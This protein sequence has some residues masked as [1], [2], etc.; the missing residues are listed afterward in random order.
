[1]FSNVSIVERSLL[2][3]ETKKGNIADVNATTLHAGPFPP[4]LLIRYQAELAIIKSMHD[5]GVISADTYEQASCRIADNIG[6][7]KNSLYR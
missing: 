7:P 4:E 3:M 1:M 2:S 5:N 6:I